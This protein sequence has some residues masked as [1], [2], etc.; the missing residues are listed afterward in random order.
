MSQVREHI[1]RVG[2]S[3]KVR[4]GVFTSYSVVYAGMIS[5]ATYS[6]VATV[7]TGYNSMAYNLYIHKG[8]SEV[9]LPKGRLVVLSASPEEIH[10][11]YQ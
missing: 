3:A 6:V 7:T 4:R 1:L 10:F 8:Q 9:A 2:E 11:R 5:D